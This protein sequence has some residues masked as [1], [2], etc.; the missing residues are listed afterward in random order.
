M[1]PSSRRFTELTTELSSLL[2]PLGRAWRQAADGVVS[3]FGLSQ[4]TALP[5]FHIV[6]L[7]DGVRQGTLAK[8]VAIESSSL[9]RLLDQLSAAGLIER[10]EDPGDR[11]AKTLHVTSEGRKLAARA[12]EA[13]DAL[14]K[15][16]FAGVSARDL[17]TTLRV[18]H[19]VEAALARRAEDAVPER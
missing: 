6:R 11:R 13:V 18:L 12:S 5:V 8:A 19:R 10:R 16:A 7:G 14:R 4:A 9:V 3:A 1:A 2:L 17:E 15:D